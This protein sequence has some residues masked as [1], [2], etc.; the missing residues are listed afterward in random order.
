MFQLIENI[1]KN[2]DDNTKVHLIFA[3][4]S[5]SDILLREELE[6][7]QKNYPEKLELWFTIDKSVQPGK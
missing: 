4:Q 7:F 3:N 1:C 5:Q 6:E 2:P